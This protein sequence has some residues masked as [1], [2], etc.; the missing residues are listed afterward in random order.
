MLFFTYT[1]L[2]IAL[3]EANTDFIDVFHKKQSGFIALFVNLG[4]IFMLVFDVVSNKKMSITTHEYVL[5]FIAIIISV[6]IIAH[7]RVCISN[8]MENYVFPINSKEMSIYVY[9]MYV[10]CVYMLKINTLL[11]QT[12]KV[13]KEIK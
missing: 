10:L 8:N 2:I 4:I 12:A 7:S 1:D 9:A 13:K 11:P 5:P 3:V 6:I